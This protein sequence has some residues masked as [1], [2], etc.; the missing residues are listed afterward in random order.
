MVPP[1]GLVRYLREFET[2]PVVH[3][4]GRHQVAWGSGALEKK[5]SVI[6][7]LKCVF[8]ITFHCYRYT[9]FVDQGFR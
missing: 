8:A 6:A 4:P 9:L 5:A 2:L 3:C 7:V 1:I